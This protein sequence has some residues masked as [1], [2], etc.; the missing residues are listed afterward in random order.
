MPFSP[1]NELRIAKVVPEVERRIRGQR[2]GNHRARWFN[3]KGSRPQK[4][5]TLDSDLY[6]NSPG[7]T[8]TVS[9]WAL[10]SDE[11]A[12]E[13]T[14]EDIEDVYPPFILGTDTLDAGTRVEI[15]K[16]PDGKWYVTGAEC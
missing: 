11:T 9:V 6:G 15:E 3:G 13:D 7:T 1:E 10:N 14:D 2:Q 12:W 5:G 4:F 8:V 16:F